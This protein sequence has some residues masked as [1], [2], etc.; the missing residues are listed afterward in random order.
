[1]KICRR[2]TVPPVKPQS[3]TKNMHATTCNKWFKIKALFDYKT[4]A[5]LSLTIWM[6]A[7]HASRDVLT[8]MMIPLTQ[9]NILST[10]AFLPQKHH[11]DTLPPQILL[12]PWIVTLN[13]IHAICLLCSINQ[14]GSKLFPLALNLTVKT[15][16]AL[17]KSNNQGEDQMLHFKS[18][19]I[20]SLNSVPYKGQETLQR[21]SGNTSRDT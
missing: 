1:M 4:K 20:I 21:Q 18:I 10:L 3:S 16:S 15:F 7:A 12:I 9:T 8:L 6:K 13:P 19:S 17:K 11:Y 2:L 5:N 14:L